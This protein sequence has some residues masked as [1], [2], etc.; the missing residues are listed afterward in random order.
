MPTKPIV[1]GLRDQLVDNL[2]NDVLTGHYKEGDPI[3]QDEVVA[4]YRVS[5]TPVREALLQLAHEGLVTTVPNC[6]AHVA[7]QAPDDIRAFLIPIR[8]VIEIHALRICFNRL[9]ADD[10][11]QWDE[12]LGAM[13]E[14]CE[15]RDFAALAEHDI[16][17]HRW[18]IELADEPALMKIWS[19]VVGQVRAHFLKSHLAYAD[20]MDVYREHAAIVA[21][22]RTSDLETAVGYFARRIGDVDLET[23]AKDL[24]TLP[25]A[26]VP[27]DA[28]QSN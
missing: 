16:A 28:S 20:L 14:A 17:F 7:K 3:R 18:L 26:R 8:R 22:F 21:T 1:R 4:R 15:L 9:T 13:R 23:T 25:V 10:F 19:A 6:G 2:R 11:Q 27:A 12:I 24:L 5:R